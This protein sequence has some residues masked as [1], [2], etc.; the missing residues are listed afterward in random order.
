MWRM[1]PP[2]VIHCVAPSRIR[3]A[4]AVG[5]LVL[6]GAV[7]HVGDGL[8]APVRVPARAPRLTGGVVDLAH[9]V[10]V[11]E[12][13][14]VG[15]V[16]AGEGP[17][18]REALALEAGGGGRHGADGPLAASRRRP[19]RG[20]GRWW[21]LRSRRASDPPDRCACKHFERWRG[22]ARFPIIAPCGR[23]SGPPPRG[24]P[25]DRTAGPAVAQTVSLSRRP[26]VMHVVGHVQRV[27]AER[28]RT[29]LAAA[30]R[31]P[32]PCTWPPLIWS[33]TAGGQP[34]GPKQPASN[35]PDAACG[36]LE[37][38]DG[39]AVRRHRQRTDRR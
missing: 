33:S 15:E 6:H 16:D 19:G 7:D 14:E 18:D 29:G 24:G 25:P 34:A 8:E 4:A 3:P 26:S 32:A 31:R 23:G 21:C 36:V 10:H 11:D 38:V 1:P 28:Q 27:A 22:A 30:D 12:R 2:A 9:L 13:V 39:G 35:A 17:A 20:R 5:V 37:G